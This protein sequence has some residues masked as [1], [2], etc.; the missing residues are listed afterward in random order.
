MRSLLCLLLVGCS[1]T[2][3]GIELELSAGAHAR[4]DSIVRWELPRDLDGWDAYALEDADGA[5]VPVQVLDG[6]LV[7]VARG[8]IDAGDV[9]RYRLLRGPGPASRMSATREE[10]GIVVAAGA[11]ELFVYRDRPVTPPADVDPIFARSAYIHPLRSPSGHVVTGDSPRSHRHQHGVFLAWTR[12]LFDGREIDFW[13]AAEETGRIECVGVTA[14]G[15]GAVAGW[16]RAHQRHVDV[17]RARTALEETWEL[18]AYAAPHATVLDVTTKLANA[19]DFTVLEHGY[20][21]FAVRG[22]EAWEGDVARFATSTGSDRAAGDGERVDWCAMAGP[23]AGLV[24]FSAPENPRAPQPVRIHPSNPYFCFAPC[25]MGEFAIDG[26]WIARYRLVAFDGPLD[27]AVLQRMWL[28]F[29][30][31]VDVRAVTRQTAE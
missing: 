21:G 6:E 4:V 19:G 1:G 31:P 11:R 22:P 29:A 18:V 10:R 12:A 24:V 15:A 30:E 20:G 23:D 28:D 27:P 17:E 5:S 25:R 7:W 8:H 14:S 13:N 26:Q 2:R 9:R 3:A 16:L